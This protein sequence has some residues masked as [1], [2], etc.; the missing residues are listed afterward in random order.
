MVGC[1]EGTACHPINRPRDKSSAGGRTRRTKR[2]DR[3]TS[4]FLRA[5]LHSHNPN[6]TTKPTPSLTAPASLPSPRYVPPA[7]L[8]VSL[9]DHPCCQPP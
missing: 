6:A 8:S 1:H 4:G 2:A 7:I 3:G 9:P 5:R